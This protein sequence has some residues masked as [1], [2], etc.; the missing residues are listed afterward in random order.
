VDWNIVV[1]LDGNSEE[2]LDDTIEDVMVGFVSPDD[3]WASAS[4]AEY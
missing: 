3:V 2:G 1:D 4:T